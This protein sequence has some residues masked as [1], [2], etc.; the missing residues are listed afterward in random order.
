MARCATADHLRQQYASNMNANIAFHALIT[1]HNMTHVRI[2]NTRSGRSREIPVAGLD[3]IAGTDIPEYTLDLLSEIEIDEATLT[4]RAGD[5]MADGRWKMARCFSIHG[6]ISTGLVLLLAWYALALAAS[7]DEPTPAESFQL[8]QVQTVATCGQSRCDC[9]AASLISEEKAPCNVTS[10]TGQCDTGSGWCCVCAGGPQWRCVRMA[11][12]TARTVHSSPARL[13]H[14]K[15][16]PQQAHVALTV[17]HAVYVPLNELN[18][19]TRHWDIS[20]TLR[21][22]PAPPRGEGREGGHTPAAGWQPLHPHPVPPPASRGR[23]PVC[24]SSVV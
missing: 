15:S 19:S 3:R 16:P 20:V 24:Q 17:G 23:E 7:S 5:E 10:F 22:T 14:V 13:L 8:A 12:V 18:W 1:T 9:G 2:T 11:S 6:R 4:M 21:P